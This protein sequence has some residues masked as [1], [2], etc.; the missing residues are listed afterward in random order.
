MCILL[1]LKCATCLEGLDEVYHKARYFSLS[2]QV[3]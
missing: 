1:L 3:K 2:G